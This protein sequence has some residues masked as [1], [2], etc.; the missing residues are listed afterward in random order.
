MGRASKR[1]EARLLKLDFGCGKSVR[2]GFEGVDVR[3]F[4]QKWTIDLTKRWPWA[5]SSVEQANASHFLEH[6][7]PKERVH[8][9]NEL[10]RVLTPGGKCQVV[11]PHWASGRAF[12]D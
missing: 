11:T 7:K 2:E 10:F 9:V 3:P 4:G 6:L 8:F 1:K 5:D 12:G